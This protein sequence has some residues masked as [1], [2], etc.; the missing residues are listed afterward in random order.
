MLLEEA[1]NK[2]KFKF[3]YNDVK[4]ERLIKYRKTCIMHHGNTL[5]CRKWC[6]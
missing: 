6:Y 1:K 5:Q 2:S 3:I 4:R